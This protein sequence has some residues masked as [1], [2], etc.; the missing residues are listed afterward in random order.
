[1]VAARHFDELHRHAQTV[2]GLADAAF[3]ERLH[4]EL[5]SNGLDVLA[6]AAE[7]KRRR[8]RGHAQAIDVR[9]CVDEL[10]GEAFTEVLLVVIRTHVRERQY[11]D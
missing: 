9:E 5:C 11:R 10:L 7:L 6:F 3:E 8:T 2:V 4:I 1:M